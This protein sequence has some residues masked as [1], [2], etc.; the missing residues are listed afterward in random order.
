MCVCVCVCV[1]GLG[2]GEDLIGCYQPAPSF[3]V[4]VGLPDVALGFHGD[5]ETEGQP[6]ICHTHTN[7]HTHTKKTYT[8][9]HTYQCQVLSKKQNILKIKKWVK[10][11][12]LIHY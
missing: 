2:V 9:A 10:T 5:L 1:W 3:C 12:F 4:L 7:T 11:P 6:L 8:H